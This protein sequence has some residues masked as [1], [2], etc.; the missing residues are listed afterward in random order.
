MRACLPSLAWFV[1]RPQVAGTPFPLEQVDGSA[2]QWR[3]CSDTSTPPCLWFSDTGVEMSSSLLLSQLGSAV[4]SL[5]RKELLCLWVSRLFGLLSFCACCSSPPTYTQ[6]HIHLSVCADS[7][8]A[9]LIS[10]FVVC[11]HVRFWVYIWFV[12]QIFVP[13]YAR[14]FSRYRQYRTFQ[15]LQSD[16]HTI[17]IAC[18]SC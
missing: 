3:R 6:K 2:H 5:E 9:K 17:A 18:V 8:V 1:V 7:R 12:K 14:N 16:G 4:W 15:S 13:L 10:A 11:L